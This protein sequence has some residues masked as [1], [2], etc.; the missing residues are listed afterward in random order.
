MILDVHD[1]SGLGV[2]SKTGRQLTEKIPMLAKRKVH[3]DHDQDLD[4]ESRTQKIDVT[5]PLQP[6]KTLGRKP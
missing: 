3:H 1:P 2:F 5:Q 4:Y 6:N